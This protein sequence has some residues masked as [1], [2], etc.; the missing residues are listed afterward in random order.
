VD[1]R[2]NVS[3]GEGGAIYSQG[4]VG[5]TFREKTIFDGNRAHGDGGAISAQNSNLTFEKEVD[6]RG[7]VSNDRGGAIY[8]FYSGEVEFNGGL[9]VIN[10]STVANAG[11]AIYMYGSDDQRVAKV[12]IVQRDPA[13]PSEFRGNLVNDY[14]RV[15]FYMLQYSQLNFTA[16]KGNIDL[17]DALVGNEANDSNSVTLENGNGW[18][19]VRRGGRIDNVNFENRGNLSLVSSEATTMNLKNFTNSGRIRFGIFPEDGKSDKIKAKN[20]TLGEGTILEL[21]AARG[22]YGK[23]KIYD[24]MISDNINIES[25]DIESIRIDIPQNFK[26]RKDLHD[27]GDKGKTYRITIDENRTIETNPYDMNVLSHLSN[28]DENQR[29]MVYSMTDILRDDSENETVEAILSEIIRLPSQEDQKTA[30]SQLQP[31]FISEVIG[32][33]LSRGGIGERQRNNDNVW[34]ESSRGSTRLGNTRGR[35]REMT[36]GISHSFSSLIP[37]RTV[38][39]GIHLDLNSHFLRDEYSSRAVVR[40]GSIG[41]WGETTLIDNLTLGFTISYGRNS[42]STARNLEKF[43]ST[44]E[45]KFSGSVLGI[46]LEMGNRFKFKN[47]LALSPFLN[48]SAT[49]LNHQSFSEDKANFLNLQIAEAK[50]HLISSSLGITLAAELAKLTPFLTLE[51]SRPLST[52]GSPVTAN[53]PESPNHK[54]E[55]QGPDISR[56][57]LALSLGTSWRLK[58]NLLL[59]L[60]GSYRGNGSQRVSALNISLGLGL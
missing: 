4:D 25:G 35:F 13:S 55:D 31:S 47:S 41:L 8:A 22:T 40:T 6:F 2:G 53:F 17:H 28:L 36:L 3:N 20:I 21:V 34:L 18:F 44:V 56:S 51:Y 38:L 60:V 33:V 50:H 46:A 12:T 29:K 39:L 49:T 9:R 48:I 23:G 57:T 59:S 42:Y 45:S 19:N 1:F 16:E 26:I 14:R 11:G 15:A 27:G 37:R 7:N 52:D 58:N 30:L 10:N 5:L 43:S 32:S 24:L 54:F